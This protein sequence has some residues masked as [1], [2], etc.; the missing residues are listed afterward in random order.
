MTNIIR[1]DVASKRHKKNASNDSDKQPPL[2]AL[3]RSLDEDQ[4]TKAFKLI[5]LMAD[6]EN[7]VGD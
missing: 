2:E 4:R 7:D 1:L 5:S 6:Y 3:I